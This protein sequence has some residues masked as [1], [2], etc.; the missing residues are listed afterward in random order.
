MRDLAE[1]M[2]QGVATRIDLT[3]SSSSSSVARWTASGDLVQIHPGVVM[4]PG[5]VDDPLA[6]ARASTLWSQGLLSHLSALSLWDV[7]P[8]TG[9]P[10]HVTVPADRSPRRTTGVVVHRT[11][12]PMTCTRI[13]DVPVTG[14]GRSL[15]DAWDWEHR[16]R[17]RGPTGRPAMV[18]QAVIE[19]IRAR[20]LSAPVLRAESEACSVHAGRAA[21]TALLHLI[22]GGC[23]SELEIWG[24]TQV[25]P[26][27][28]RVPPPVQ[29]HPVRLGN[30]RWVRLDAAYPKALVAVEL[31]GAAFHGS[32]E[33]RERDLRRDTA[34]A[35]LGW[36]VLRFSYA[37]LMADP[38]GCRREI[39]AVVLARLAS[40]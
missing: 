37:R 3:L 18:R 8:P 14:L 39:E 12:L 40:R 2:P 16:K 10:V 1:L 13:R 23:E 9:G 21:L 32:R 24:V 33:P 15:V 22:E 38:E 27:A 5:L 7:V 28:P 29:Q 31:D 19:A 17:R 34:L 30:G 20:R 11:T 4:L 36:V 25:L 6:R 26:G 35:A